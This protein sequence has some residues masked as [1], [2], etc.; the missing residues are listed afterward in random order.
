MYRS[1]LGRSPTLEGRLDSDRNSP[2]PS[3]ERASNLEPAT[4]EDVAE[5][6]VE[7]V[8]LSRRLKEIG[9]A[10]RSSQQSSAGCSS[11]RL[12]RLHA[13]PDRGGARP[14]GG[15]GEDPDARGHAQA[16]AGPLPRGLT[17]DEDHDRIE[18]LLAGYVLLGLSSEDATR[19]DGLLSEHVPSCP[20]CR[21][22]MAGFQAVVGELG[23]ATS[24]T[25][26]ADLLL[27]QDRA[28]RRAGAS[29]G[30][31]RRT[32]RITSRSRSTCVSALGAEI[33]RLHRAEQMPI[34]R[35]L[36]QVLHP[37]HPLPPRLGLEPGLLE[38]VSFQA[39]LRGQYSGVV[40]TA[41][42]VQDDRDPDD[43]ASGLRAGVSLG[44]ASTRGTC[45][46][47][48]RTSDVVTPRAHP[49]FDSDGRV[50]ESTEGPPSAAAEGTSVPAQQM[51][52]DL[53]SLHDRGLRRNGSP[54]TKPNG[55]CT[56]RSSGLGFLGLHGMTTH[57]GWLPFS[58]G[59]SSGDPSPI[60]SSTSVPASDEAGCP[61][62]NRDSERG[63]ASQAG[64][65]SGHFIRGRD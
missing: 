32:D 7:D 16:M 51:T 36:R 1:C 49:R 4:G 33:R 34:T 47:R 28:R 65:W 14:F 37:Q 63:L 45:A 2:T 22:T 35:A 11:S 9:E 61:D 48:A 57:G 38:E 3:A 17:V 64:P 29:D 15:H 19:A 50:V 10:S 23:L 6:V 21:D 54:R 46:S 18:E 40:D 31:R 41:T 44:S 53:P 55:G 26:P 24:P 58:P 59:F 8:H 60:A 27:P 13:G 52:P 39:S 30:R 12:R 5:N 42:V 56:S 20:L 43:S 25:R 62:G